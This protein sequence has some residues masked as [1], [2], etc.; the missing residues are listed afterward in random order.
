MGDSSIP[1]SR[2]QGLIKS[3]NFQFSFDSD[4]HNIYDKSLKSF[5]LSELDKNQLYLIRSLIRKPKILII[6]DIF[7]SSD[8]HYTLQILRSVQPLVFSLL[9]VSNNELIVSSFPTNLFI[10]NQQVI[11]GGSAS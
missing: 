7:Q 10:S 8:P 6:D 9:L 2:I 5:S 1:I 11:K 3:L 4:N